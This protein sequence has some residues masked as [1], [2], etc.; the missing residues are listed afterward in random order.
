[1]GDR[2]LEEI[3]EQLGSLDSMTKREETGCVI[4][5]VTLALIAAAVVWLFAWASR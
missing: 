4:L 1:M 3:D 5:I 2:E